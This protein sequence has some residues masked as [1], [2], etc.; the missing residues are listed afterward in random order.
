MAKALTSFNPSVAAKTLFSS[1]SLLLVLGELCTF[2]SE[3]RVDEMKPDARG[4]ILGLIEKIAAHRSANILTEG[5]PRITLRE[6]ILAKTLRDEAPIV[7][8][9]DFKNEFVH[10]AEAKARSPSRQADTTSNHP[11]L[12]PLLGPLVLV[13]NAQRVLLVHDE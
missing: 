6:N 12:H 4:E 11:I 2:A 5:F 1:Q 13:Q 9:D 10:G 8:P 3:P 7:F